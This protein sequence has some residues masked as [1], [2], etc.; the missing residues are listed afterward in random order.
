MWGRFLTAVA[1]VCLSLTTLI[2]PAD[3]QSGMVRDGTGDLN[4]GWDVKN[5]RVYHAANGNVRIVL[6]FED[7][8]RRGRW[9]GAKVR[10]NLRNTD[11]S[12]EFSFGIM[13]NY[14]RMWGYRMS[15]WNDHDDGFTCDGGFHRVNRRYD[16]IEIYVPARCLDYRSDSSRRRMAFNI[17]VRGN[18]P[19]DPLTSYDRLPDHNGARTWSTWF[20]AG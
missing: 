5:A 7:L 3:A 19:N 2:G 14:D 11:R 20:R 12:P 9:D 6:Y 17:F 8:G 18:K 16:M 1:T 13:R 15:S 10:V 4:A